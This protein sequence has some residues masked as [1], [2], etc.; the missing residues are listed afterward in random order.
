MPIFPQVIACLRQDDSK[1][2]L[3]ETALLNVELSAALW[4]NKEDAEELIPQHRLA[5]IAV[6]VRHLYAAAERMSEL[7]SSPD[8]RNPGGPCRFKRD[9]NTILA[10]HGNNPVWYWTR[11]NDSW[12]LHMMRVSK[13]SDVEDDLDFDEL[14]AE[15]EDIVD[16]D[17]DENHED[18]LGDVQSPNDPE[19]LTPD[20]MFG[21][22]AYF[23]EILEDGSTRLDGQSYWSDPK[24]PDNDY[25]FRISDEIIV[26]Y[27]STSHHGFQ[28]IWC[29]RKKEDGHW[30]LYR[31]AISVSSDHSLLDL[32]KERKLDNGI[33]ELAEN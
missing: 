5:P 23:R 18:E 13:E 19:R 9:E 22:I 31:V 26:A 12:E 29:W 14:L 25:R 6:F 15:M 30:K 27:R 28:P 33:W 3:L 21:V 1:L 20:P 17:G 16:D 4:S 32:S 10:L 7:P 8:P 2:P 24:N 11:K